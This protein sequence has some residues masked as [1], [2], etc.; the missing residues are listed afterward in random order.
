MAAAGT[1]R[2]AEDIFYLLPEEIDSEDVS[3]QP[4]LESVV[5][6]RRRE[7]DRWSK[8]QPPREI[9]ALEPAS[10]PAVAGPAAADEREVHGIAASRGVATG[11]AKIVLDLAQQ[12]KLEPGDILVCRTTSPPWTVLFGRAAAVVADTGGPLAHTAIAAREFG[13]P[14]VVGARGATDRIQDGMRITVD[15]GTGV[16]HL[17]T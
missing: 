8:V 15:G 16:V 13:I 17:D 12:D 11:P 2:D 7:W 4:S 6:D 14:C 5:A 10:S 9:G 3:V 1:I